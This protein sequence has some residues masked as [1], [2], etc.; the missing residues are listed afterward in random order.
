ML[1]RIRQLAHYDTLT[2][3]PNRALFHDRLAHTVR[4]AQRTQRDCALLFLDMDRFKHVNDTLGHTVGDLLLREVARR[5][6]ATVRASDTVARLGGDEFVVI[7]G[8]LAD[9]GSAAQVAEKILASVWQRST[10]LPGTR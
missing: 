1:N 7:L 3:L 8:N 2:G 10:A 4:L 9:S 6:A 5:L